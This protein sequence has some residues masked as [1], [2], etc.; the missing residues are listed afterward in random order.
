MMEQPGANFSIPTTDEEEIK[1][2]VNNFYYLL[3]Y[4]YSK[5]YK[6]N[7]IDSKSLYARQRC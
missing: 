6:S 2:Q 5:Q 1:K 4:I 7:I 3:Y